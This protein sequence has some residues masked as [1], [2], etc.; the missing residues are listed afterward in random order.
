MLGVI[1]DDVGADP[2]ML[3]V[4]ADDD[5]QPGGVRG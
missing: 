1:A 4:F 2:M 3:C 5:A